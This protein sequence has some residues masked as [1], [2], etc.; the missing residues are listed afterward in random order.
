MVFHN[1][2]V[3]V[4]GLGR[5]GIAAAK[6]L[7]EQGAVVWAT[8][9]KP[10]EKL[11]LSQLSGANVTVIAGKYP[12]VAELQPDMLVLSPGVPHTVSPIQQA[13]ALGIPLWSEIEL[14]YRLTEA[15]IVAIT[16][17]NGKTTTTAL[18]GQLLSDAGIPGI[19]AGNIGKALTQEVIGLSG[20]ETIIAEV[21]SF[22]LECI[23]R[24]RAKVAVVTNL[25]PDHLDRHGTFEG[26]IAAKARVLENQQPGDWAILNYDDP[27]VRELGATAKGKVLFFSRKEALQEGI[28]LN[29]GKLVIRDSGGNETPVLPVSEILIRGPHNLENAMAATGVAW[30]LGLAPVQIAGTLRSFAGVAHRQEFVAEINGVRYINDSKG[31]NPDAAIKALEAFGE[32]IV[33]IAGGKNKGCDFNEFMTVV[34][35]KVKE[36]VL[37]GMAADELAQAATAQGVAKIHRADAFEQ[38]VQIAADLAKPGDVVLLS[39]ACTSWDMFNSFEERGD[40][41]KNLVR[42][43]LNKKA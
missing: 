41:F 7:A 38:A 18:T 33:L 37:L 16:G 6:V 39:P 23:H 11:D 26:Y 40:L 35:R 43:R 8:D 42:E 2:K 17:T 36:L 20:S 24:F 28:C 15:P 21:S 25:T 31:T 3:L 4:I 22:Q 12:N 19:V 27:R 9:G 14:A 10:K 5:S 30:A 32:P 13:K 29:D 1:K 34:K